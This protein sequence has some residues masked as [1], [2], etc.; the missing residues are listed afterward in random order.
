[1]DKC[2]DF[3]AKSEVR[4]TSHKGQHTVTK[5]IYLSNKRIQKE[6]VFY[7]SYAPPVHYTVGT[8][9][10]NNLMNV[11]QVVFVLVCSRVKNI[12]PSLLGN[13][14]GNLIWNFALSCTGLNQLGMFIRVPGR[15]FQM[16]RYL[17]NTGQVLQAGHIDS[18]SIPWQHQIAPQSGV[19]CQ[20]VTLQKGGLIDIVFGRKLIIEPLA[21][22]HGHEG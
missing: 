20:F 4:L 8:G 2:L 13:S 16:L 14:S 5:T 6:L 19:N 15:P 17:N 9:S 22:C 11:H 12:I 21:A 3:G 18:D 10:R 1:M 7:S